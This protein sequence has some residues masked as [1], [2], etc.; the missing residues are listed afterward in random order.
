MTLINFGL[1]L[2]TVAVVVLYITNRRLIKMLKSA[3]HALKAADEALKDTRTKLSNAYV[4]IEAKDMHIDYLNRERV[5]RILSGLNKAEVEE[6]LEEHCFLV[7]RKRQK[8]LYRIACYHYDPN[9][10]DDRDYIRIHS[11]EVA[12][13]LNEKP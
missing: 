13:K 9:D 6:D 4:R 1:G 2:M 3:S 11:E 5:N 8:R 10:P 12:D 7:L